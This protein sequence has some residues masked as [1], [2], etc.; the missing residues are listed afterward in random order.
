MNIFFLII[1]EVIYS[2][3]IVLI[4][5]LCGLVMLFMLVDYVRECFFYYLNVSDLMDLDVISL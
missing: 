5:I 2:K 4:D 3:C 1:F